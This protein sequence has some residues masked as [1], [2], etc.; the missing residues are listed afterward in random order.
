MTKAN[1]RVYWGL[2]VLEDESM[3]IIAGNM[4]TGRQAGMVLRQQLRTYILF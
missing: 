4:A 3:N 2:M 1:Q